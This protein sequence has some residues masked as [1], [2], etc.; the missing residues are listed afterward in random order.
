MANENVL[1]M[2]LIN[3][4]RN[5]EIKHPQSTEPYAIVRYYIPNLTL[6]QA[7]IYVR[8]RFFAG[9]NKKF[10]DQFKIKLF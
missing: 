10:S 7:K 4:F 9:E 3:G 5:F 2:K 8:N 1:I 6:R